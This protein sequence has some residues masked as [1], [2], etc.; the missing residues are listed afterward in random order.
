M[1]FPDRNFTPRLGQGDLPDLS[2]YAELVARDFRT[3]LELWD[4]RMPVAYNDLLT[5]AVIGERDRLYDAL[6]AGD[7]RFLL[8]TQ[9]YRN[10]AT[11][12]VIGDQKWWDLRDDFTDSLYPD[13][14]RI[15]DA[16]FSREITLHAWTRQMAKLI[17]SA[18]LALYM[19]G[20]GGYN[21]I[22]ETDRVS[23]SSTLRQQYS[24][25]SDFALQ[26]ST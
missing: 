25:L 6:D 22:T 20:A 26:V 11:S 13:V 2:S 16:L 8:N 1:L 12:E 17:Q 21:A 5:A 24:F 15:A 9:R 4:S 19:F 23:L 14:N 18:H 7:W 10:G 3:A